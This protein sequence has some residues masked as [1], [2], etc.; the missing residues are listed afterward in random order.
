MQFIFNESTMM[1]DMQNSTFEN[2]SNQADNKFVET[3]LKECIQEILNLS[4]NEI[5]SFIGFTCNASRE[6]KMDKPMLVT[7]SG[8]VI[9]PAPSKK[10]YVH[11]N[12]AAA[13]LLYFIADK[14]GI[15]IEEAQSYYAV[16][17]EDIFKDAIIKFLNDLTKK[18]G[19][20]RLNPGITRRGENAYA[21]FPDTITKYQQNVIEDFV[22]NLQ[23]GGTETLIIHYKS[24]SYVIP[25]FLTDDKSEWMDMYTIW[26]GIGLTPSSLK[27]FER[28][29]KRPKTID[30]YAEKNTY[31]FTVIHPNDS[32]SYESI[33][34][35]S[36][37][38][39]NLLAHK[40]WP[41]CYIRELKEQPVE[42]A[43]TE[44]D[45]TQFAGGTK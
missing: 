35:Y 6:V 5:V 29:M 19:W 10:D 3:Y 23:M 41:K 33:E 20:V 26:R 36:M 25:L 27:I 31:T 43:Q 40:K 38:Q 16:P 30:E 7:P 39:A 9:Y 4:D 21:V 32:A 44:I 13:T 45:L 1:E 37:A 11:R 14:E 17:F 18:K 8:L 24:K 22:E 28:Y 15:S 42:K 34:A 12:M 2:P